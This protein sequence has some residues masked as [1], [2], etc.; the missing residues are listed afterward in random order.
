MKFFHKALGLTLTALLLVPFFSQVSA[1]QPLK[2]AAPSTVNAAAGKK[3]PS[4]TLDFSKEDAAQKIILSAETLNDYYKTRKDQDL[5]YH[6]KGKMVSFLLSA[7]LDVNGQIHLSPY[8]V[9]HSVGTVRTESLGGKQ[10]A[11]VPIEIYTE[12]TPDAYVT[13]AKEK[14]L[15]VKDTVPK[16]SD[17]APLDMAAVK[18]FMSRSIRSAHVLSQDGGKEVILFRV[19][20]SEPLIGKAASKGILKYIG[21][22]EEPLPDKYQKRFLDALAQ[23]NYLV[24]IDEKTHL[25]VSYDADFTELVRTTILI[26]KEAEEEKRGKKLSTTQQAMA[27][28]FLESLSLKFHMDLSS[29]R[30]KAIVIPKDVRSTKE[31][32]KKE[33]TRPAKEKNVPN[34]LHKA[35]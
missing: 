2:E 9:S 23:Q 1:A 21:G 27:T 8:S 31:E 33:A 22:S 28:A 19:D 14:D 20:A 35:S 30:G 4:M 13:Y 32:K 6:V 3:D 7:N 24:T 25:P 16:E 12:E 34:S 10:A 29:E 17:A 11:S 5:V 26:Q 18:D 15:W